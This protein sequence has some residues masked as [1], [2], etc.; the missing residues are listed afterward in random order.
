MPNW[1]SNQL[2]VRGPAED[3]Q[4]FKERA[5]GHS[6]WSKPEEICS[7]APSPLNLHSLAPV[8]AEMVKAGYNEA[9]YNWEK[10]HWG[11]KWGACNAQI[12]DE[13]QGYVMYEFDTAWT[14]PLEF[15][16][17]VSK[18]WPALSL[19]LEYNEPGN[20]FHG[21]AEAKGGNLQD[22]CIPY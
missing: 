20:A 1:C 2:A 22:L 9:A 7:E 4:R 21:T 5:I 17:Q 19:H 10:A 8:P 18:D 12:V 13:G 6:P 14:P 3:L 16:E 11:C 15:I